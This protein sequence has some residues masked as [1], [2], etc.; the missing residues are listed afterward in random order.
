M[1][2]KDLTLYA[3]QTP[4]MSSYTVY[5]YKESVDG[6]YFGLTDEEVLSG[7]TESEVTP[8]PK[9][10][11]GFTSPEA[12]TG[13]VNGWGGPDIWYHYK[14]N[15]YNLTY[16]LN[17]G[18]DNKTSKVRYEADITNTPSRTGYAFAGWYTDEALTQPY[19]QTTMPAHDLTLYAKWE[20]GMKTYQVRHYQQSIGNSEQYDLAETETVTA[21]TG[22]HL[23]LAVKAYEGFTAPKPVSYDVVDD[24]EVTYVDY[25]YTRDRHQV[26]IHYNNG[27]D[28]ETKELAYGEKWEEK[29]YRAGYVFAGWYT[30]AEFKKA[31]DGVVPAS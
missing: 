18:E 14:R 9:Q 16:V 8:Q 10:Y 1:P 22:E 21:K 5:H 7:L 4:V 17:N 24:G 11:E 29:P 26:T 30:D 3:K 12:K 31:F 2:D 25:K 19:V 27:N 28:S 6:S 20:A 15:S 23:T 13:Q